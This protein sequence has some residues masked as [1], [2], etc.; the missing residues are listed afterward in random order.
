M[1]LRKGNC[2]ITVM[3]IESPNRAKSVTD[4]LGIG[5]HS[6]YE[7]KHAIHIKCV[8]SFLR[9]LGRCINLKLLFTH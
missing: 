2:L 6:R 8:K 3:V 4:T 5:F 9:N 7:K 1:L